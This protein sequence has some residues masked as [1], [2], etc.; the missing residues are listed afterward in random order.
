MA[1]NIWVRSPYF[2]K[3]RGGSSAVTATLKIK[4]T[5]GTKPAGWTG[6][7]Q[8][9]LSGTMIDI[10]SAIT[11]INFEVAELIKDYIKPGFDYQNGAYAQNFSKN[12]STVWVDF[13]SE[14]FDAAGASL[15]TTDDLGYT[16]WYGFLQYHLGSQSN[17]RGVRSTANILQSCYKILRPYGKKIIFPISTND[18]DRVEFYCKGDLKFSFNPTTTTNSADL[19]TYIEVSNGIDSWEKNS[20]NQGATIEENPELKTI[21]CRFDSDCVDTI[22][23]RT[24]ADPFKIEVETIRDTGYDPVKVTFINSWGALQDL[25]FFT[26]SMRGL[27]VKA[28]GFKRNLIQNDEWTDSDYHLSKHQDSILNKNGR[29]SFTLNTGFYPEKFNIVFEELLLSEQVWIDKVYFKEFFYSFA[30]ENNK[31]PVKITTSSIG[32]KTAKDDKLINYTFG[33]EAAFSAVQDIR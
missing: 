14:L 11:Q 28:T 15:G 19:I 1:N 22:W 21:Q 13:R 10:G 12:Y 7:E 8:Y 23:V 29:E 4:I 33:F 25:Y 16:A 26:K 3:I 31:V 30:E 17:K 27:S 2:Y 18:V 20:L 32:F 5:S 9:S 6:G 24:K